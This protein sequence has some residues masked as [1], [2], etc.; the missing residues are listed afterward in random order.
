MFEIYTDTQ[1]SKEHQ[2]VVTTGVQLVNA[3][4][5]EILGSGNR[6]TARNLA[7]PRVSFV[8]EDPNRP[9]LAGYY[10]AS[11]NGITII[12]SKIANTQEARTKVFVHEYIHYLSH[13]GRDDTEQLTPERPLHKDNNVGFRR[14]SGIDI[15]EGREGEYTSDYFLSF[16]EAVTEQLAID[17]LPG[18]HETYEDYRGLLN[19]VID[20]AVTRKLGSKDIAGVF[21]Q[22]TREQVKQYIYLCYFK[23]DHDG[24]VKLLTTTYEKYDLT[25]QQFGLMTHKNDLPS[26]IERSWQQRNPGPPPRP[27]KVRAIVEERI[28]HKK[29]EDYQTD[30]FGQDGGEDDS[31][32]RFGAEYD[33][34]INSMGIVP[35]YGLN[36]EGRDYAMDSQGGRIY[37]GAESYELLQSVQAEL[38][39]LLAQLKKHEIGIAD[40]TARVD[41]LLFDEHNMSMLS[42]GFREF[43]IY[44]HTQLAACSKG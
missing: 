35:F 34:Y 23:G 27:D 22:W 43:Y 19:Q 42:D 36:L 26:V 21:Q 11:T 32:E 10:M 18:V 30:V 17:I 14:T 25:E 29:P 39:V 5:D 37:R 7:Y 3:K 31:G 13:N 28:R 16:N 33:A 12:T 1:Q 40:V 9:H 24:F 4:I 41:A 8:S 2:A 20:D 38:D 6:L 15:R 44:K